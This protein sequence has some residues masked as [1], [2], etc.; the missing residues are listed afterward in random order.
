MNDVVGRLQRMERMQCQKPGITR[1]R[2]CKPDFARCEVREVG[3]AIH[4]R[5]HAEI[6]LGFGAPD[7]NRT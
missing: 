5:L 7:W 3:K 1:A 6:V 4:E 2:A